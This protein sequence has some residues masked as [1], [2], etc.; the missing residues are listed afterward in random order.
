MTRISRYKLNE[1][2]YEKLFTLFFEV[3]TNSKDK[4]DFNH[5]IKDLFSPVER[6]MIAKRVVIVYL[7]IQEIDYRMICSVLKVSNATI[8]KFKLLMER[9]D[10]IVP[11]LKKIIRNEK[12]KLFLLELIDALSPPGT[13]GTNWKNAWKR[14]AEINRKKETGIF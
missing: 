5:L 9:S 6:I 1:H 12:V 7:L 14:R 3:V 8:S 10:G 2:V 4:N 11:I 13:Y